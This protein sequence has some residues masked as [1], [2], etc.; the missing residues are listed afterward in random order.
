M[1]NRSTPKRWRRRVAVLSAALVGLSAGCAEPTQPSTPSSRAP[2]RIVSFS[3]A[4]S[5]TLADLGLADHV[6]GRTPFCTAIDP[7]VAIVGDLRDVDFERLVRVQPTHL[8]IQPESGGIHPTL[9]ELA[10]EHG[11]TIGAWQ[12]NTIEDIR[13]MVLELPQIVAGEDE[14]MLTATTARAATL[15]NELDHALRPYRSSAGRSGADIGWRDRVLVITGVD[16]VLAF[17]RQTYM[18]DVL[19]AFGLS[20]AVDDRGWVQLSLEDVVRLDPAAIVLVNTTAPEDADVRAIMGPVARAATTAAR[21][22]R[23]RVLRHPDALLPS[24]AI[25]DVADELRNI[26][27]Q[28]DDQDSKDAAT[29]E[30]GDHGALATNHRVALDH[31]P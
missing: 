9:A 6:V 10:D 29:N 12:L 7:S 21:Q 5:R 28:F 22:N 27:K 16:P 31:R 30:R 8:L 3:P 11:W 26:C 13:Q 4:I 20:N 15:I 24:T 19:R 25:I 17:G 14:A 2:L 1:M 23:L 18:D